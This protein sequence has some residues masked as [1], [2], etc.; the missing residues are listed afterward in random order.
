M[1]LIQGCNNQVEQ[2]K[3]ERTLASYGVIWPT[4]QGCDAALSVFARYHL[5]HSLG[6]LDALIGETAITINLPIHTFNQKH[7]AAISDLKTAHPYV[8][9]ASTKGTTQ[10]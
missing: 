5:S 10:S 9:I 3:V 6:L 8:R 4:S 2:E 1:E 7:Y